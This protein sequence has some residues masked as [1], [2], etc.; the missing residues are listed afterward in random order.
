MTG[1]SDRETLRRVAI[2][3]DMFGPYHIARI[4]ALGARC[5]TL[6][7]EVAS[8]SRIYDWDR[9]D[10]DVTFERKTLFD[11]PD[12][13]LLPYATIAGGIVATLDA[14]KPDVVLIPGWASRA[15]VAALRWALENRVASVV[16]S[17]STAGDK[18]R[19]W[20]RERLK[21]R[22]AQCF[23]AG[24]VGGEP[25]RAYL[26]SLGM[27]VDALATGYN[28]VD[29]RF[30]GEG[31]LA[32]RRQP[33]K[34]RANH[35][36]PERYFLAS[37]RYVPDKNLVALFEAFAR[38]RHRRPNS[39]T[40]MILLGDGAARSELEAK[41]HDL[42]LDGA[43]S[44]PGFRQYEELPSYYGLALAFVHISRIEPWGLVVNEA[45]AA[46][47]P[48]VVSR[49]CG[50]AADLVQ[51]GVNGFLVPCD[52]L[53]IVAECLT[54]IDDAERA[55]RDRMGEMSESI[56]AK[57]S[58]SAFATGA[59]EASETAMRRLSINR[60]HVRRAVVAVAARLI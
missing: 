57:W 27:P 28:V 4:N 10:G 14:F 9:H 39:N 18:A 25:Q 42:G 35:D 47:L 36:L 1:I 33:E 43:I 5:E 2:I 31:A 45:M 24:F 58:P 41:R 32:A 8:R 60:N 59:I 51:D 37:A 7:I 16:M 55:E 21:G 15:A 53:D 17:E 44:M 40:G 34:T 22:L 46:G 30:F 3:F 29:I 6:G 54:R 13:K 50:C 12:S 56:I 48:I 19:T 20:W 49:E 52:D 38:F 26:A 11:V 23:D